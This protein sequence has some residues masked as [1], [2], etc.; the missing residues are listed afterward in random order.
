LLDPTEEFVEREVSLEASVEQVWA[1]LTEPDGLSRWLGG[2]VSE[3]DIRPGGR[4]SMRRSDGAVRRIAVEVVEAPRRLRF[5]WWP[6]AEPGAVTP[7]GSSTVEF[8]LEEVG[9]ITTLRV[10][11]RAPLP[12]GRAGLRAPRGMAGAAAPGVALVEAGRQ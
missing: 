6:F 4:G 8:R 7:L 5:R 3:L 12:T 11:E 2:A 1:A 10:I 9:D